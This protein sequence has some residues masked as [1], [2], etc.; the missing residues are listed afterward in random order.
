MVPYW[1]KSWSL[2]L[3]DWAVSSGQ[4]QISCG[5]WK[6]MFLSPYI[7]SFLVNMATFLMNP[8]SH[9]RGSW[10]ARLMGFTVWVILSTALLKCSSAEVPFG[11][12]S[13]GTQTS[14][15][16]LLIQ[17]RLSTNIFPRFPCHQFSHHVPS[18][19][20][21]IQPN[22]CLQPMDWN[23]VPHLAISPSKQSEQPS[24]LLKVLPTG[25]VSLYCLPSWMSQRGA[26]MLQT[27]TL[28]WCLHTKQN[29]L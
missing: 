12:H 20:L 24:A 27:S 5:E 11:E 7:S 13:N 6:P 26:V 1:V 23:T 17:R 19:S 8:L 3:A 2:L 4:S 28:G 16:V 10:G 18:V 25:R 9:D 29:H 22:Q 15:H 21:T 14:S